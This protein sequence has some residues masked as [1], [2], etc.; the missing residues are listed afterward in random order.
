MESKF[1]DIQ[2]HGKNNKNLGMS[3]E[4]VIKECKLFYFAGQATTSV[5]LVWTMVLLGQN[6]NWQDRARQQVLQVFGSNKL[7]FDGLPHR[8]VVT[9]ILLEV[10]RLY[11]SSSL[12]S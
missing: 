3:I 4:D 1:K 6:Q 9:M 5:L 2:E 11:P 12:I 8:K 10:L 7:D